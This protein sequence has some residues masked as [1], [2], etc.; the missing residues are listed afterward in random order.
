[1]TAEDGPG[2][3][4][5]AFWALG[6]PP[7]PLPR[8][9]PPAPP[10]EVRRTPVWNTPITPSAGAIASSSHRAKLSSCTGSHSVGTAGRTSDGRGTSSDAAAVTAAEGAD[11]DAGDDVGSAEAAGAVVLE[12]IGAVHGGS[13]LSAWRTHSRPASAS[14]SAACWI[15]CLTKTFSSLALLNATIGFC[16]REDRMNA[17]GWR[18]RNWR[19]SREGRAYQHR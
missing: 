13:S 10:S 16:G 15:K 6:S 8:L 7:A 5:R 2:G 4:P 12:D 9:R 18:W 3:E 19:G 14:T 17:P 1:M 11:A